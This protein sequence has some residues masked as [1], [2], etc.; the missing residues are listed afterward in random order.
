MSSI[1]FSEGGNVGGILNLF[2]QH[3]YCFTSL[4]PVTFKTGYGWSEMEFLPESAQCKYTATEADNGTEHNY[5][6]A[7]SFNKQSEPMYIAFAAYLKRSGIL[8]FTDNNGLTQ[9]LGTLKNRVTVKMEGDTGSTPTN[10]NDFKVT[11]TW[12]S[13]DPAQVV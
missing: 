12:L 1:S 7:F 5:T 3:F 2:L 6:L 11:V 8:M 13:K 9:V 4:N 10:A